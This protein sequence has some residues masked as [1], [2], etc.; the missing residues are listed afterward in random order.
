ML[1][2]LYNVKLYDY[3]N[4][5]T[6]SKNHEDFEINISKPM[7]VID[8][9]IVDSELNTYE[10]FDD[11]STSEQVSYITKE[12]AVQLAYAD[13]GEGDYQAVY[14]KN[15]QYNGKEYFLINVSWRVDDGNGN[16][17]YSHIGYKI[18]SMDG[19][20]ILNA[21]YINDQVQVY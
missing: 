18:V 21:D 20:E 1:Y 19:K 11:D 16:F 6:I 3:D 7:W 10:I 17:H 8:G 12:Q 5:T 15:V 2:F 14:W 9:Y 13:M 4:K